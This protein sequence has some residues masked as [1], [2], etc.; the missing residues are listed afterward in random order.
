MHRH[1][2]S[3]SSWESIVLYEV[4]HRVERIVY[5]EGTGQIS[6]RGE[7]RLVRRFEE[8]FQAS[9]YVKASQCVFVV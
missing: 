8:A 2:A 3:I 7:C 4:L 6:Y 9:H 1:M 5:E